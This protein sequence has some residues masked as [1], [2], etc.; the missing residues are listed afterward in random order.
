MKKMLRKES[1]YHRLHE[2]WKIFWLE[3]SRRMFSSRFWFRQRHR[4]GKQ[5]SS[6]AIDS[7]CGS[8][9]LIGAYEAMG[10]IFEYGDGETARINHA[11]KYYMGEADRLSSTRQWKV[12]CT[13]KNGIEIKK[14]IHRRSTISDFLE[15]AAM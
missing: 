4:E 14:N 10:E 8:P 11:N 6:K 12:A 9:G 5:F 1:D 7:D 2:K 15:I 3:H 13:V